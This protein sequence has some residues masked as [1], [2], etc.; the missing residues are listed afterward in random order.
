MVMVGDANTS[1]EAAAMMG[2]AKKQSKGI[3]AKADSGMVTVKSRIKTTYLARFNGLSEHDALAACKNL[4]G[5]GL[6]CS[7]TRL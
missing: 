3:L 2:R 7:A 6:S 1:K 4:K 5:S